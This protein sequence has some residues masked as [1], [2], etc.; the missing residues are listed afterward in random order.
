MHVYARAV[1]RPEGVLAS[2][3]HVHKNGTLVRAFQCHQPITEADLHLDHVLGHVFFSRLCT[4]ETPSCY[5]NA[6]AVFVFL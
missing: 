5:T 1:D 6:D 3:V 4:A 2:R